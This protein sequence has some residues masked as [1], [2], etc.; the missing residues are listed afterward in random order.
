MTTRM[1]LSLKKAVGSRR[2]RLSLEV[3]RGSP[4]NRRDHYSPRQMNDIQLSALN[5]ELPEPVRRSHLH[6]GSVLRLT[7]HSS[8]VENKY[9]DARG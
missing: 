2:P 7:T 4:M 6:E 5:G 8:V 9:L 3:P 1:I